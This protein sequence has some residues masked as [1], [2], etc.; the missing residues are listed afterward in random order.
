[1]TEEHTS[2]VRAVVGAEFSDMDI[3]RAL[4]L[5]NNDVT[6]AINII[7]DTPNFSSKEQIHKNHGPRS[8]SKRNP[9][10]REQLE[11]ESRIVHSSGNINGNDSSISK[12][13]VDESAGTLRSTDSEWWFVGGCELA[14]LSTCKGRRVKAGDE[15]AFTFP[16]KKNSASPSTGK[17]GKGRNMAACSEIVRF[18]VKD[19]GEV[20]RFLT[21]VYSIEYAVV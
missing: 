15:V 9:A 5:A 14:G 19:H 10:R 8:E 12:E 11:K 1:M 17:F 6:A 18:S 7:F 13:Y 2:T 16:L 3:V 21:R 20:C 4:H